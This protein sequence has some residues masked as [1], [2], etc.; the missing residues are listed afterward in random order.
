MDCETFGY[1]FHHVIF[2]PKLPDSP[3]HKQKS[4]ERN[5]MLIVRDVLDSFLAKREQEIKA[6]WEPVTHMIEMWLSIDGAA[7]FDLNRYE[8]A[9]INTLKRLRDHGALA[10]YV[11]EQNCGW[12]AHYDIEMNKIIIDAFETSA[13][14]TAVLKARG[15][16]IR[17]FPGQSVAI[18][19]TMVDDLSF[20][21]YLAHNLCRLNIEYVREMRPKA[22]DLRENI[23]ETRDTA[24]PGLITEGLM[25]QL[26]AFGEHSAYKSF[27][28]HVSDEVN[29]ND[30]KKAWRRSPLWFVIKVAIQTILYRIFP[31]CE[32]RT[33]YKNFMA[34]LV[35]ELGSRA[36]N[37]ESVARTQKFSDIA[38][39]LNIMQAKIARRVS[40]LQ[41]K[42]LDFVLERVA[43]VNGAIMERLQELHSHIRTRDLKIVPTTFGP[44]RD[45][46]LATS[47]K[48][49]RDHLRE[50][51]MHSP[52]VR[53]KSTFNR[54]HK[55]RIQRQSIGLPKLRDGEILTLLDF[56]AWVDT[57]L[58]SWRS[59]TCL[60]DK[61]CC[62]L[63]ELIHKYSSYADKKYA[64]MPDQMSLMFLV[65]MELWVALDKLCIKHCPHGLLE[66]FSPEIPKKFL[67]P[68][69]LPHQRQMQR[70]QDVEEYIRTRHQKCNSKGPGIFDDPGPDTFAVRYFDKTRHHKN[71]RDSIIRSATAEREGRRREWEERSNRY[72]DLLDESS[73]LAH[74]TEFDEWNREIH[75]SSCKKCRLE[76]SASNLH[77]EVHEWP[78]PEDDDLI[79]NIVFELDCPIWFAGWR[80]ITWKII[81]EYGRPQARETSTMEIKLLDYPA[82]KNFASNRAP[83]LTLAS[84][85]KSWAN[86]HYRIQSFPVHFEKVAVGNTLKFSL[87]DDAKQVWAA[88]RCRLPKAAIKYLCIFNV[89]ATAYGS[90]Q[91]AVESCGHGQNKVLADQRICHSTLSLHEMNAFGH[92]RSGE[93]LQWY[94]ITRELA[95]PHI[96]MNEEPAH[97]LFCQA[98]WE[99]GS[100]SPDSQLRAAH[101]FFEEPDAVNKLLQTLEG[102]LDS[103]HKNW[104][105]HY[106][107]H[108]IV[109]LGLRALSLCP[110]SFFERAAS[111]LRHCR[112]VAL[113]W[114]TGITN[115]LDAQ[116]GPDSHACLKLL[117]RLGGICVLTYAVEDE[118]L[119]ALLQSGEDLQML[120]RS[121][122]LFFENTSQPIAEQALE[123]RAMVIQTT[124]ILRRAEQQVSKLIEEDPTGL[125]DAV[126]QTASHI[127]I[128]SAWS[129]DSG[130]N[131]RWAMNRSIQTLHERPQEVRYN[132]LSG[133]LLIDNQPPSRLPEKY[134]KH[135]IFQRLFGQVRKSYTWSLE[136]PANIAKRTLSVVRSSLRGS[137]STF[138]TTKPVGDYQ[139]HFGLNGDQ[140][141]IKAKKASQIL[142]LI[143]HDVLVEDF[144]ESLIK[145]HAH[146]LD[147]ETGV[148][149][150]RPLDQA[151]QPSG[152]NWSMSF[153]QET[154]GSSAT[155]QGQRTLVDIHNTLFS[156]I[157]DVL[158]GLDDPKHIQVT[159]SPNGTVEAKLVRLH[160]SFFINEEKELEC[161][162]HNA[163]VDLNQDIGCFYG[164][165]N[166]LVL[167]AKTEQ[168]HRTVLIPHGKV[169]FGKD[170]PNTEVSIELP[171]APRIKYFH[172]LL[173]SSLELLSDSTGMVGA[174]YQ[175]YLHAVTAFV[176]PDP[177]TKRTGTEEALRI[178][179]QARMKSPFPLDSE[180]IRL[181]ELIAALTPWRQYFPPGMEVLQRVSWNGELCALA[182][183]DDFRLL[184]QEI[185]DNTT[186]FI[187]FWD[188]KKEPPPPG[189][190]RGDMRLLD[191]ARSRN[192]HFYKSEYGGTTRC[193]AGA[194]SEY[195]ARD[196]PEPASDRSHRAYEI[197][198][199]IRNWPAALLKK[200]DLFGAIKGWG[201]I[202]TQ[203]RQPNQYTYTTLIDASMQKLWASL[204]NQCRSSRRETDTYS[205]ISVFCMVA[206]GKSNDSSMCHLRSLLA[207]AF[208]GSF[209]EM[210]AQLLHGSVQI[211]LAPGQNIDRGEVQSTISNHY[212]SFKS[213]FGKNP[214]S[215]PKDEKRRITKTQKKLYNSTKKQAIDAL[216]SSIVEQWPC[217]TLRRP[218]N[219]EPWQTKSFNDCEQLFR[220]SRKNI[221]FSQFVRD[222]QDKLD[223]M[224]VSLCPPLQLP[225]P[226]KRLMF[227]IRSLDIWHP[228]CIY[229]LLRAAKAPSLMD[230]DYTSLKFERDQVPA[231]P[232]NDSDAT[233]GTLISGLPKGSNH[234]LQEYARDLLES[235]EALKKV[236]LPQDPTDLPVNRDILERHHD[237]ILERRNTL[238][239]EITSTLTTVKHRW[240]DIGISILAPSVTVSSILS[241]LAADKWS[242]VP[243]PWK[244]ILLTFAKTISSLRR[245]ERL[246]EHFD[247]YDVNMF[248]RE[249]ETV[250]CD[251]WEPSDNPD[252]LLLEIESDLTIRMRQADI[253]GKMITPETQ[254]NAVLQLNMGEGKT[255]VI[256]PMIAASLSN[257][258]QL[259]RIIVL[260]PLLRQSANILAQRL[261]GLLNRPVY[262]VPF[263]RNTKL[264]ESLV[265][266]LNAIY[267]ECIEKRGVLIVLPEQLLSLRL[268]GLDMATNTALSLI[269]L[270]EELQNRCR[271]IIDESDEVLDPKF[272]LI[273]TRGNQ[274]N[275]DGD[276]DRWHIIQD[277]LE[278]VEK[279]AVALQAE[280]PNILQVEQ[281]GTRYPL[282]HFLKAQGPLSLLGKV[283][284]AIF[285]QA[286]PG[287]S[288]QQWSE[289]TR[290]CALQFVCSPDVSQ[291]DQD[292]VREAFKNSIMLK[293]LLVLRGLFAHRILRFALAGKRWWVDYGVHPSR[294]L[295]AVPFRAKGVPSENA[296]FGHADVALTLTCLSYYYGGLSEDQVRQCFQLILKDNDPGV[297]YERWIVKIREDLPEGLRSFNGVNLEDRQTF[298]EDLYPRLRYQ[299]AIIDFFLSKVVFPKEAKEFPFKLSTSA[300]DIPSKQGQLL[301]TGFSGTND[302]RYMLPKSMPQKDLPDLLH[303]NAMVLNQ[304]LREENMRCVLAEN[305]N[306]GQVS[307]E[308]L[309][310]LVNDQ[311]HRIKVIIDVGA[312]ILESSNEE[313]AKAWL[314]TTG[315]Q[316]SAAIFY[317]EEDEAV[318]VDHDGFIEPLIASPFRGRMHLCLVFLD[319]HHSR[320]VDLKLPR[321]YR[322]AVTLGPRLTKDRLVQACNRMREL[323]NGQSVAFFIPP[324]VR[325]SLKAN[326]NGNFTSFEVIDWVLKQTCAHLENLRPLWAWQGLQYYRCL[327]IWED[328][329]PET[330]TLQDMV[331]Q[332]QESESKTLSQLYAPWEDPPY[333]LDTLRALALYDQAA[334]ELFDV[335]YNSSTAITMLHEEQERE[336]TQ[337]VQREQQVCRPRAVTALNHCVHGDLKHF[338]RH[339]RFP[340]HFRSEAVGK[341]PP[342]MTL[343]RTSAGKFKAPLELMGKLLYATVDFLKS[344]E[345]GANSVDDEFLKPVHWVLSNVHSSQLI[346]IS[347]Y[348]ANALIPEIRKSEK[349]TLHMYAPRTTKDM[350]S[351]SKLDFLTIGKKRPALQIPPELIQALEIFSGSLYFD[352]FAEYEAACHFFGFMTDRTRDLNVPEECVTSEGFVNEQGRNQVG[353]PVKSP[354]ETNPLP[355]LKA[356]Y[357]TR[358]KGHGFAQSH[359]GTIVEARRLSEDRF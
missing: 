131:M 329:K 188:S 298:R 44:V 151:W 23:E 81:D 15:P 5:L 359:V 110:T 316:A 262:Y 343:L 125:N 31:D 123:T 61:V 294:C 159:I 176:L 179:R 71:L 306:G 239:A 254:S 146:W 1:I 309:L 96:S 240:E 292:T 165:L 227:P 304:L 90:H 303:T 280:D 104:N 249:A 19:A 340:G 118:H 46:D 8:E 41:D 324:E 130:D 354:F 194:P 267:S 93:N 175:A 144:P 222:V 265:E 4:L 52:A 18:P 296:E 28:K 281:Q 100:V 183:H 288:F 83:R 209:P 334:G 302:N 12:L 102:R 57:Q 344:I 325:H 70:A 341:Q 313:V 116:V 166:K 245:C 140:L 264:D 40:K 92:L 314:A 156:Q 16:L 257:G 141:V 126:Q 82:T 11:A 113:E 142:R 88:V 217:E 86:T 34:F 192:S 300:W 285:H 173:D 138:M 60:T 321:N 273:Y 299:K 9:L 214:K 289:Q 79:K 232:K 204:Y 206:F 279:E 271:T 65:I 87:W 147:L 66:E 259:A 330:N 54:Q 181:L 25:A 55:T 201:R 221:L 170:T 293:R 244:A 117:F 350:C 158:K 356:W 351:F 184:A 150:F 276:S 308:G 127:K 53:P 337:E 311:D 7:G 212:P 149:E 152:L 261:G 155:K 320:G 348:E 62:D 185:F 32:G 287:L 186:K 171:G 277:V 101:T 132:V 352:T 213:D 197:A 153:K 225:Q 22:C 48:H 115:M 72:Q 284:K 322:A 297:E 56:E 226:P 319:Q 58:Q 17:C 172:Y 148:L 318:V 35:V 174:L 207:V 157:A 327:Q 218:S 10:L 353:W 164:L 233:L 67:Q 6:R 342:F 122:I 317:N 94:N 24:H 63:A 154:E 250:S 114:C 305:P 229:D 223:T 78:L 21:K 332:I 349:V 228:P 290:L 234:L 258:S 119:P 283:A 128:T 199:L 252:W 323:G 251:G 106:T 3:E 39:V 269:R 286:L 216:T 241:F 51:M 108:T 230:I 307:V 295:M 145:M 270:Q 211:G 97:K 357:S 89:S 253:V 69:L 124:R 134:T 161:R 208:S 162:E 331:T 139:V 205:L 339:G 109:V 220:S 242:S 243:E 33:E 266:S 103:I 260:K 168:G 335:W 238:W 336:I 255:T 278:V 14:S 246:Q 178:L 13:L 37:Q 203:I 177:A 49:S 73:N 215:V 75:Y 27:E 80:D 256:T 210:P 136:G 42:T 328:F 36:R 135:A 191:R 187:R 2:P 200:E 263:S 224:T 169:K 99:F 291:D 355:F 43:E 26:L 77:I 95:S 198:T 30:G 85:T 248:Y 38:S 167:R 64:Q 338:V 315:A 190:D 133:E 91:Y 59:T 120:A 274:Q 182:Q 180:S 74:E 84:S 237:D 121:S 219:M 275:V 98:A 282:L 235:W 272:Q 160:L 202:D 50:A 195:K 163:I 310:R 236:C 47:L 345:E 346:I 107:L 137:T 112:K 111:L 301:T 268:V 129:F 196:R 347:Q 68:L 29:L 105:E 333:C 312:Q 326:D 358:T 20:C 189:L 45:I 76:T 247:N 231:C 193:E 143:P